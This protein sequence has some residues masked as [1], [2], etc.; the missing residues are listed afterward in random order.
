MSEVA[1]IRARHSIKS[2]L[3]IAGILLVLL[4]AFN[5]FGTRL[6]DVEPVA[7]YR[8]FGVE[9]LQNGYGYYLGDAFVICLGL[10]ILYLA[11][12]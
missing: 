11:S 7:P 12:R 2:L 8:I 6:L 9:V 4:G 5:M 3:R 10:A 1:L